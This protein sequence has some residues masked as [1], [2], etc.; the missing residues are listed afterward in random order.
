MNAPT[1]IALEGGAAVELEFS[2]GLR[3][4]RLFRPW[5]DGELRVVGEARC[6]GDD[7]DHMQVEGD[8]KV[9][10]LLPNIAAQV[11]RLH[12]QALALR[13]AAEALELRVTGKVGD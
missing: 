11:G 5:T 4:V 12:H 2:P 9:I 10:A 6:I 13:E 7:L 8:A 3:V 1:R